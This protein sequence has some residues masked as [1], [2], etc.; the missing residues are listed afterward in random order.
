MITISTEK[1]YLEKPIPIGSKILVEKLNEDLYEERS[2]GIYIPTETTNKE[3]LCKVVSTGPEVKQLQE[4]NVIIVS[5][6]SLSKNFLINDKTYYVLTE[7][8]VNMIVMLK[9]EDN[10]Y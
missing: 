5:D 7:A 8:E 6:Y 9:N 3:H 1:G 4:G 10:L 2:S